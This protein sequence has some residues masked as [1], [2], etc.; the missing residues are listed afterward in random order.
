L[1]KLRFYLSG[2]GETA[3]FVILPGSHRS[4]GLF[5]FFLGSLQIHRSKFVSTCLGGRAQTEFRL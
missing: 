4:S 1:G 2:F 3:S 5:Q